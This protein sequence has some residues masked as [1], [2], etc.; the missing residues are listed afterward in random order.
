MQK[1]RLIR[2]TQNFKE[3]IKQNGYFVDKTLLIQE[4]IDDSHKIIL[5]PRPRRFGKSL[6]LSMLAHFFDIEKPENKPLFE[7]YQIWKTG[8][9]YT[10]QQAQYPVIHFSLKEIQGT[11]YKACLEDMKMMLSL[12]FRDYYFLLKSDKLIEQEKKD[13]LDIIARKAPIVLLKTSLKLLTQFLYRHYQQPVVVLVDEYDAP[14]HAGYRNGYY[15]DII[16]FMKT[17][18]GGAL[19]GEAVVYKGVITGILRIS[20]ESIF[21]DLNNIEV[22]TVLNYR[23]SNHFGFTVSETKALL[24]HF[25]LA[26][27]F[28]LVKKWYNGY[29]FGKLNGIYNPWSVTGYI[30]NHEEGFNTHWANTSSDELIKDRIV[31]KKAAAIR[32]DIET[33]LLGETIN[34]PIETKM[35]FRDFD[36]QKELLWTLLVLSGY[37]TA[38]KKVAKKNYHLK[39][40]NY[41][42][43]TLFQEI[44]WH[45]FEVSFNVTQSLLLKMVEALTQNRIKA[46]EKHFK[47]VM[48]DTMSYFD[49]AKNPEA[50]WQAYVLGLLSIAKEDYIIRSNR[51][52]GYG[53][54]DILMLPKNKTKYGIVLEI[55]A[56]DKD[57]SQKAMESKLQEAL[58]QIQKN[59]Y[60]KELIAHNILKR[61]EVAVVF[62]GKKV[63]MLAKNS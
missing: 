53:R 16:K 8:D 52:S 38:I 15:D 25:N 10:Q 19:K 27:N 36:T 60:Y 43:L 47:A 41:E 31:E 30:R 37:L 59:E 49:P 17:F 58:E 1:K 26:E 62:A 3:L 45:W 9:Y 13:I 6:N 51:E 42:I 4:I 28:D 20:R 18:L 40:P 57:T 2:G 63:K 14:I 12:L 35:V 50:V 11:T 46:F 22:Y 34:K 24:A 44:I 5:L 29:T 32:S 7:P 33:L 61:I 55:K 39:I 56:V 21:S 48:G 54:Y 23:Y